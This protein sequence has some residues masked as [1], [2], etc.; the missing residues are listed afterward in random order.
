MTARSPK[1]RHPTVIIGIGNPARRDDGIGSLV[2]EACRA[3]PWPD[4]DVV[5]LDGEATRL[6][7]AWQDRDLAIVVDAICTG[8]AAGTVHDLSI[9]QLDRVHTPPMATSS[10]FA[11]LAEAL[12]LGRRLGRLPASLRVLGIEPADV[13]YGFGLSSA[14]AAS[15]DQLIDRVQA[16]VPTSNRLHP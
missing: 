3:V 4:C 5:E 7:D 8:D 15:I 13:S 16:A 10:H 6:L 1:P 12:A 14:V 2:V 9:D 11:G